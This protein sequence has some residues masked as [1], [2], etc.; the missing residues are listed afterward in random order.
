MIRSWGPRFG[1]A[2][3][4]AV[5]VL[6]AGC[7]AALYSNPIAGPPVGAAG[8]AVRIVFTDKAKAAFE[9][10]TERANGRGTY[11]SKAAG[12]DLDPR[13]LHDGLV[14]TLGARLGGVAG[15]TAV[16]DVDASA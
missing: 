16:V 3:L 9:H 7:A 15:L 10:L 14:R 4:L 11:D 6:L 5:V 2:G 12:D 1:R 8:G 13:H